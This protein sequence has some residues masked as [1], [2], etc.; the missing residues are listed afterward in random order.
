MQFDGGFDIYSV[1][2]DGSDLDRLT[3]ARS[4]YEPAWSPD[5]TKI[6]YD[7]I[8]HGTYQ[9][10]TMNAD[11]SDREQLSVRPGRQPVVDV[12]PRRA[13]ATAFTSYRDQDG[14]DEIFRHGCRR[15]RDGCS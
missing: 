12:V 5:G 11:G 8:V 6:A 2:V 1:D 15:N 4:D 14:D 7:R 10:F 13:E 3:G 9:I